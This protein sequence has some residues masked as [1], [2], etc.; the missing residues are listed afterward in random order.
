MTTGQAFIVACLIAVA[1]TLTKG[2]AEEA[3]LLR[4]HDCL[5]SISLGST[6][7]ETFPKALCAGRGETGRLAYL[8]VACHDV[9]NMVDWSAG[10]YLP[11][12]RQHVS[13]G[14]SFD[15]EVVI[16]DSYGASNG[17]VS[18][19]D[20]SLYDTIMPKMAPANNVFVVVKEDVARISLRGSAKVLAEYKRRCRELGR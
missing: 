10:G 16:N 5:V 19:K 4:V 13:T 3:P 9:G 18:V 6:E 7:A 11:R 12:S 8:S 20:D 2:H 17:I 15:G 14:L 1:F